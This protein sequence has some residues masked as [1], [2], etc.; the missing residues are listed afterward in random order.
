LFIDIAIITLLFS[1]FALSHSILAS[2][3]AKHLLVE[4]IGEK[5]AF[6]RLFY[7]ISSLFLFYFIYT[8]SP[9][10]NGVIYDLQF[11]FDI[12]I[13]VVQIFAIFGF[14]WG[15]SKIN[16]LEFF[17]IAQI[18]R[19]MEN[20]YNSDELDEK[21]EL[22]IEGPFRYS[23]HPIYVFSILFLVFRPT[24]DLFYLV[25]L[26]NMLVYFYIGSYFEE[27]KM[28]EFFGNQYSDYQRTVSRLFP[29]KFSRLNKNR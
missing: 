18:N 17:G 20:N 12:M 13:F 22:V 15:A 8:I 16:L 28:L 1:L 14:I 11:P 2:S 29:I 4:K 9:K 6:Y 27:K 19:Y 24:M 5:I 21:M 23:R 25:F 10:P 3:K 7:N 26:I